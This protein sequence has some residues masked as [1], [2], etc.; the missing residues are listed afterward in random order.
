M[1]GCVG[2]PNPQEILSTT[3]NKNNN[4]NNK[5]NNS[6][7]RSS[8]NNH[9]RHNNRNRDDNSTAPRNLK[10][11]QLNRPFGPQNLKCTRADS[12]LRGL[13][14][15]SRKTR[16]Q[17]QP[18]KKQSQQILTTWT[19][20]SIFANATLTITTTI[21]TSTFDTDTPV[22]CSHCVGCNWSGTVSTWRMWRL[23]WVPSLR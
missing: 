17:Q 6:N 21:A 11:V 5:N 12:I 13:L 3:D 15:I 18:P 19:S 14:K 22:V 16:K 2:Q 10:Q 7:D 20:N 8:N 1:F 9:N 4:S 23:Y